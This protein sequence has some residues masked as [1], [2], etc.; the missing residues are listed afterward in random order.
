[1]QERKEVIRCMRIAFG[2]VITTRETCNCVGSHSHAH[3][4]AHTRKHTDM[5]THEQHWFREEMLAHWLREQ[6]LVPRGN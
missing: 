6:T 4:Y 5:Y 1:M 3:S 2:C